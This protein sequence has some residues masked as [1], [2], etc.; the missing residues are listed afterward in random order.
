MVGDAELGEESQEPIELV[1]TGKGILSIKNISLEYESP[2][3]EE[4][5]EDP[6]QAQES[7]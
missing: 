7:A 5:Q 6:H 4:T 2:S 1:N 3:A